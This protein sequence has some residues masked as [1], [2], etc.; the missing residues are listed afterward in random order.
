M[1]KSKAILVVKNLTK[2]F[3]KF[4]AV[5]NISLE[6]EEG[7]ITA[8]IGPNGAGKTTFYN[9]VTGKYKPTSGM[10]F[11]NGKNIT[12]LPPHKIVRMGLCRSFQITNIFLENTVEEN[13]L[14]ALVPLK[15]KGLSMIRTLRSHTELVEEARDILK[16]LGLEEKA[17]VPAKQLSYGD[18][19]LVEIGI[20]IACRPKMILLDEPTAGMTPS[21]TERMTATIK[22]LFKETGITFM[23]TE[24]DMKVVFS[25]A[26]RIVVLHQGRLLAEGTPQQIKENPK[27]KEAYLGGSLNA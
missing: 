12:G 15:G 3:G 22:H 2:S 5:D 10:I 1:D 20:A 24:H 26:D 11:F 25:I 19:R 17:N 8:L 14:A 23:L 6:V 16:L 27:V 21:E 9:L 7:K 13:I 18:K 4:R